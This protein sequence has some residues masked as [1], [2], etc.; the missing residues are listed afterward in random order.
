MRY[1]FAHGLCGV[2]VLITLINVAIT[3]TFYSFVVLHYT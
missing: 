3:L 1:V 2:I